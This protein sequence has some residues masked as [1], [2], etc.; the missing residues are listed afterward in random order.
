MEIAKVRGLA[1]PDRLTSALRRGRWQHPGDVAMRALIPWFEEPLDFLLTPTEMTRE[2]RSLDMFADDP[3]SSELF[4][5]VRGSQRRAPVEL[6]WLDI[7]QAVLIAVNRRP[8]DDVALAL[9]YRTD[10]S[11][12]RVVGSDFWTNPRQCAWRTVAPAFS[13]FADALG[14]DLEKLDAP[15]PER[16]G[17]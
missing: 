15:A 14:M 2:S 7:E 16:P 4:R 17:P 1:L 9:D 6:P 11:D 13:V 5:E 12:P 8:G 10:P 3:R